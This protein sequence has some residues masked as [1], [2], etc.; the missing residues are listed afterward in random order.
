MKRLVCSL[1]LLATL[2]FAAPTYAADSPT[3]NLGFKALA[4]QIP[5]VVGSPTESE[6]DGANGDSL[7][8]TTTGLMAWRK[9]DNWTAFTNGSWTWINGPYGVQSRSNDT[10]F[11]WEGV[12][13]VQNAVRV[14]LSPPPTPAPAPQTPEAAAEMAALDMINKSRQNSGVPPVMMNEALRAVARADAKDM[15]V[16]NFFSHTNPDGLQP[17][18]R[19]RAAGVSFSTFAENI[20]W[21]MGYANPVDAVRTNHESMMAETP[22]NDGHRANILNPALK[23]VGIGVYRGTDGKLSYVT[24]FLG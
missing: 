3:F 10:R 6:H 1:W 5:D 17:W 13:P 21:S 11:D 2:A 7:Q 23:Q 12:A 14:A 16:R 24:D 8:Q 15:S 18:D 22:P 19:A 20:G 9:A 4:D